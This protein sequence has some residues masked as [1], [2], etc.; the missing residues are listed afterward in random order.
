MA[1][2]NSFGLNNSGFKFPVFSDFMA[3]MLEQG[4]IEYGE[5]FEIDPETSLG[6]FFEIFAYM[7]EGMSNIYQNIY[8]SIFLFSMQGQMLDRFAANFNITRLQ[9]RKAY[10]IMEFTGTRNYIIP[11]GF[12]VKGQN[13]L[14]YTLAS[15]VLL[16]S[17]GTGT[18]QIVANENGSEYNT[19]ANTVTEKATGDENVTAVTNITAIENGS[20]IESDLDFRERIMKLFQ[21]N[22]SASVN[23]IRKAMLELTQVRD[24]L[25]IE[26]NTNNDDPATGLKPGE[27]EVIIKGLIDEEVAYKLFNTRSAGIRTVGNI[28]F[29]LISD[30]NQIVTERLYQAEEKFLYIQ[31]KDIQ[32]YSG[33]SLDEEVVIKEQLMTR[34]A[35]KLGLGLKANY[36]KILAAVYDIE[37]IEEADVSISIDN[38]NF[39]KS[40]IVIPKTEYLTLNSENITVI[41]G[42]GGE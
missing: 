22:E 18:G 26:N 28:E 19:L 32:L 13:G 3:L 25:V 15:N 39:V 34:V 11:R 10:G 23:G 36:E 12:E 42:T 37:E 40:D 30:S 4:K 14:F 21:G 27:I 29:P 8:D 35:G 38:T 9:G 7:S 6:Q 1:D 17:S 33:M 31:V 16:D 5:E 20:D 2:F 24:C 41:T